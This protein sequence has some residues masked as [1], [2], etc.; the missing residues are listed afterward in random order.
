MSEQLPVSHII[1]P[2][3]Q[4]LYTAVCC[5]AMSSVPREELCAALDSWTKDKH[6]FS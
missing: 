5:Q 6:S 2:E 4:G 1:Q 3:L